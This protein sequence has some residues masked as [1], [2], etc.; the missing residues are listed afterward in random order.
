MARMMA[1]GL[2]AVV[3][4]G[5]P[6]T[7]A[8]RQAGVAGAVDAAGAASAGVV[9][10]SHVAHRVWDARAGAFAD[11]ETLAAAS[12][13]VDV[14]MF[15]EQHDDGPTHRLQLA[16][17][18]RVARRGAAVTL[19]LEM[20]ERDVQASLDGYLTGGLAEPEF[21]A[22]ARPWPNYV[23]HYRPLVEWARAAG[24][25][26]VASNVPRT[27]ASM[28][29][30]DGLDGLHALSAV[31][32]GGAARSIQCPD[33]GYRTRFLEVIGRHPM[34][35]PLPPDEEAARAQ[36]YYLSQCVKDETMAEA[37]VAAH[38][39]GAVVIHMTGAF[40]SDYGAGT[41]ERVARR[42][43]GA[44]LLTISAIPV[45]DL[46]VIDTAAHAGRADFLLFTERRQ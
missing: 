26:V 15:G 9:A 23:E 37:V 19:S 25:P 34:G 44:R 43:P 13:A 24:R 27:V 16:L 39:A 45:P 31:E 29:A 36:R 35:A 41:A 2:L 1:A 20:F 17:L 22:A 40:H 14:V 7:L 12:A 32:R 38:A 21:L 10:P 33:D 30:R 18:E 28:V 4:L 5:V 42:M 11:F 6:Q 46:D 3:W 8:A